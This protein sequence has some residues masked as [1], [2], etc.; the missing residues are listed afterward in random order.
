[1]V[2][3]QL[4]IYPKKGRPLAACKYFVFSEIVSASANGS[5]VVSTAQIVKCFLGPVL[6]LHDLHFAF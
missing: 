4:C 6:G 3:I 5:I 2:V 1:M